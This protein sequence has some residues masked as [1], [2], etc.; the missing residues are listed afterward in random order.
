MTIAEIIYQLSKFDPNTR[1]VV[2]GYEGGF[3]DPRIVEETA[4]IDANWTVVDKG[5][6]TEGKRHNWNGRHDYGTCYTECH[7]TKVILIGR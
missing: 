4:I 6:G 3:D 1:V 2:D 7:N 5:R